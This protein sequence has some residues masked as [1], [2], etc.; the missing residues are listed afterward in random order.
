MASGECDRRFVFT[1]RP[2]GSSVMWRETSFAGYFYRMRC[3]RWNG[4]NSGKFAA[5]E[6]MKFRWIDKTQIT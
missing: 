2:R 1:D 4:R 5:M 6:A 3:S